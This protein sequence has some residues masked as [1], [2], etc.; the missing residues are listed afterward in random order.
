VPRS[1]TDDDDRCRAAESPD[2]LGL[3][4][5]PVL[6]ARGQA[7]LDG[8]GNIPSRPTHDALHRLRWSQWRRRHQARA[9][10]GHYR[11]QAAAQF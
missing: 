2:G 9:R 11:R 1:C 4:T 3:A 7:A 6:A 10:D 5:K 8:R